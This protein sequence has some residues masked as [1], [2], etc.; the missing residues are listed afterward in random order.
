MLNTALQRLV[1]RAVIAGGLAFFGSLQVADD[2]FSRSALL[3]AATT[4]L[5]AALE[6]LTPVNRSVG[7]GSPQ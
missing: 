3:A 6:L 2:P 5:W 7:V 1:A 4:A